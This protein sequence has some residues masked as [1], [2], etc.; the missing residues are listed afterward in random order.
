VPPEDIGILIGHCRS[1]VWLLHRPWIPLEVNSIFQF[2]LNLSPSAIWFFYVLVDLLAVY[3]PWIF[4]PSGPLLL[5]FLKLLFRLF[6]SKHSIC[7]YPI[8]SPSAVLAANCP[9]WYVLAR[10]YCFPILVKEV[11][12]CRPPPRCW[13]PANS[14]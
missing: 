8:Q 4:L 11:F 7:C 9:S 1:I 2:H 14:N 6:S 10:G 3:F 13:P 12:W 5:F